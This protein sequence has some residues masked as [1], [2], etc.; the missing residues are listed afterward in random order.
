MIIVRFSTQILIISIHEGFETLLK[1][2]EYN[3][4]ENIL[5]D[6]SINILR[7]A[8]GVGGLTSRYEMF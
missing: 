1:N 5:W 7:N 8:L 6:R 2:I 3:R 4:L